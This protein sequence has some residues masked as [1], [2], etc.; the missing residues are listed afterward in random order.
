[1]STD[2]T[3]TRNKIPDLR[4]AVLGEGG[5]SRAVVAV[6]VSPEGVA[7]VRSHLVEYGPL[8]RQ[9]AALFGNS[10]VALAPMFAGTTPADAKEFAHDSVGNNLAH[11]WIAAYAEQRWGSDCQVI[12][13]EPWQKMSDVAGRRAGVLYFGAEGFPYYTSKEENLYKAVDDAARYTGF[14]RFGFIVS[15]AVSLP[16]TG[17]EA[18][19]ATLEA[20]ARQTKMAFMSAY[21]DMGYVVWLP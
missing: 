11:K 1:L 8:S 15:P 20:L 21:D 4:L 17:A 12:F 3:V 14:L 9:V 2:G 10:G 6:D 13:E 16:P 7:F 5:A 18:G 19:A